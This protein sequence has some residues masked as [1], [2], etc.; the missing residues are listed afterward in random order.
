MSAKTLRAAVFFLAA[1]TILY[2]GVRLLSGRGGGPPGD[3]G[4]DAALAALNDSTVR[5][6]RVVG[7]S[8]TLR[9]TR[10]GSGWTVNGFPADSAALARLWEALSATQVGSVVATNPGN[11]ARLGV[12]ADSAWLLEAEAQDPARILLGKRG[13]RYQ[14]FFARLPD[15][16]A[17]YQ[18]EGDLH[19]AATRPLQDW[20][21]KVVVALDTGAVARIDGV[22]EG[23]SWSLSREG[24]AWL[25]SG[26]PADSTAVRGIL[27]ELRR[28]QASGFHGEDAEPGEPSRKLVALDATGDT[29]AVLELGGDNGSL[30]ARTTGDPVVYEVP[31][32]RADRIVPGSSELRSE[33]P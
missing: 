10:S 12:A 8:D 32:W 9:L 5:S 22:R 6:L 28:F 25:L 20:R 33:T 3:E 31:T 13:S 1:V 27:Q 14:T 7:P 23:T 26:E 29:L 18:L 11:H 4:L 24:G 16:D 2:L 17:V 19:A 15:Q 21:D 30:W